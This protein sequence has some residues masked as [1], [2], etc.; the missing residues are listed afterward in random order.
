MKT[1]IAGGR[2]IS[3]YETVLEA[4][5]NSNF[6]ITQII[7]GGAKGVDSTGEQIAKDFGIELRVFPADWE[8]FGKAAGYI[9]NAEMAKHAEA[10]IAIWDGIS[11]GTKHMINTA[12]RQGL[13][14]YIEMV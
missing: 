3:D 1:I 11:P 7:S 8:N 6:V 4:V 12:K 5:A 14:T 13:H 2:H 10:L 9:R